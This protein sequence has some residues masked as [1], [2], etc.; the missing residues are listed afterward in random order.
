ML[1]LGNVFL[2]VARWQSLERRSQAYFRPE[3]HLAICVL[4]VG[5]ESG[6]HRCD[7]DGEARRRGWTNIRLRS[8]RY[9]RGYGS[10]TLNHPCT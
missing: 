8:E 5:G 9:S 2:S 6:Y 7:G 10:E 3:S 1:L 4:V